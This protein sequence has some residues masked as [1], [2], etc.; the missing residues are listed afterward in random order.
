MDN[1][2]KYSIFSFF[3]PI[4]ILNEF[5]NL[6]EVITKSITLYGF[7]VTRLHAKF[8]NQFYAEMPAKVA[9]GKVQHREHVYD[10]LVQGGEAILAVQKGHNTA[11]AVVHVADE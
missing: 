8:I 9:S 1:P 10:G 7:A 5:Q 6:L 4:P 11:K 2:S 3:L